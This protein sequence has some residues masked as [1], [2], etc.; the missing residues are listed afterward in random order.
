MIHNMN[1]LLIAA[2]LIPMACC[3]KPVHTVADN[4]YECRG[5]KL[6]CDQ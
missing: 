2:L 6:D 3:P 4:A 5:P 1:S